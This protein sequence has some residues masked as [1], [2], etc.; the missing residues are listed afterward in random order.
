MGRSWSHITMLSHDSPPRP[1]LP[2]LDTNTMVEPKPDASAGEIFL[3]PRVIDSATFNEFAQR[4]RSLIDQ[5]DASAQSLRDA[6]AQ[7]TATTKSLDQSAAAQKERLQA[8]VKVLR[9]IDAVS[10]PAPAPA[11]IKLNETELQMVVAE[12][13]KELGVCA[14]ELIARIMDHSQNASRTTDALTIKL[15]AAVSRASSSRGQL[16]LSD[17]HAQATSA[18][19]AS[20]GLSLEALHKR[21]T[22]SLE[23]FEDAAAQTIADANEA[24]IGESAADSQAIVSTEPN[25]PPAPV[26][27]PLASLCAQAQQLKDEIAESILESSD[28]LDEL[29]T[30][31]RQLAGKVRDAI[32]ACQRAE[33]SL[34]NTA[35]RVQTQAIASSVKSESSASSES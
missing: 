28:Q 16:D 11:P 2:A 12:S 34:L 29:N 35:Q 5:A 9:A 22:D 1:L 6:M 32:L 4:L 20:Q 26:A 31:R 25:E 24:D 27:E 14:D 18:Q 13:R 7:A 33:A 17:Q 19:L 8:A 3:S 30:R 15:D 10:V 21:I 23:Q